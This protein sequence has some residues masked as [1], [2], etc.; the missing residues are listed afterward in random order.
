MS[1]AF[2]IAAG[3]ATTVSA[4]SITRP[5][6][7]AS[8]STVAAL[9]SIGFT[10]ATGSQPFPR[11]MRTV[12]DPAAIMAGPAPSTIAAAS[13]VLFT[14]SSATYSIPDVQPDIDYWYSMATAY[15]D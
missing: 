9:A 15:A 10:A 2:T 11:A 1:H 6:Y 8:N 3:D 7:S 14:T 13:T 5:G 4:T 12:L